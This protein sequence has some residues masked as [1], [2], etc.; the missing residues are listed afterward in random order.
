MIPKPQTLVCSGGTVRAE[1]AIIANGAMPQ[2][3]LGSN[4]QPIEVTGNVVLGAYQPPQR[5]TR[6]HS[7]KP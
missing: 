2:F 4:N 7:C 6:E 3:A 5:V 1:R